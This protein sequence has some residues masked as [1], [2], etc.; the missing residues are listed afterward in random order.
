[1][2]LLLDAGRPS[3]AATSYSPLRAAMTWLKLRAEA[4][5]KRAT[6]LQLIELDDERLDD[7]GISRGDVIDA[8][9][10]ETSLIRRRAERARTARHSA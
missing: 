10:G 1:M 9:K 4:R 2:A 8:L 6:L 3:N 5:S 7:L